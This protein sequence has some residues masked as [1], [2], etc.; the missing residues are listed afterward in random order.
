MRA[1]PSEKKL[2][3]KAQFIWENR[4][5]CKKT[6]KYETTS[7]QTSNHDSPLPLMWGKSA[8][9]LEPLRRHHR[10]MT[11]STCPVLGPNTTLPGSTRC[12][13]VRT[14]HSAENTQCHGSGVR[15]E[16]SWNVSVCRDPVGTQRMC[17]Y[18]L[19]RFF[20]FVM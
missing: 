11:R 2:G 1:V 4:S 3:K 16:A 5:A 12:E 8:L 9:N 13:G 19:W 14:C 15:S 20:A 10:N 6:S 7:T 18:S 17:W